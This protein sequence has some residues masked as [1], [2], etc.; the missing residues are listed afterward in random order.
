M[1]DSSVESFI[2][3][4]QETLLQ[5]GSGTSLSSKQREY[6]ESF[7]TERLLPIFDRFQKAKQD[8]FYIGMVGLTNVGKSTLIEALLGVPIAP[9]RNGPATAVPVEYCF[10]N[11]WCLTIH[12]HNPRKTSFGKVFKTANQMADALIRNVL[13][14]SES[15]VKEIATTTVKGPMALLKDG[16]IIVDT[17][18]LGAATSEGDCEIL[19][20]IIL[21]EFLDKVGRCYLCVS[22]GVGWEVSPEESKFYEAIS[23]FC[24]DVIVTKWEGGPDDRQQWLDSFAQ[25]FPGANFEFVNARKAFNIPGLKKTLRFFSTKENRMNKIDDEV[26]RAW[27]D[28]EIHF[29]EVFQC[30]ISWNK[31]AFLRFAKEFLK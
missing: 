15:K 17:P 12:Y 3:L 31:Y 9:K 8:R 24:T 14:L 20:S 13:D 1:P 26:T 23:R 25:L 19:N 7:R 28:L 21:P 2:H 27:T 4:I 18:G 10:D 29:H 11:S 5:R 22:A 16:L 30:S 6:L